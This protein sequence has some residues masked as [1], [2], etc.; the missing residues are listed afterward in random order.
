MILLMMAGPHGN[1]FNRLV[2]MGNRYGKNE[3]FFVHAKAF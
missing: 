1:K 2:A 3:L